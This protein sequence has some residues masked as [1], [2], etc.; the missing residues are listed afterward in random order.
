[1]H[2]LLLTIASFRIGETIKVKILRDGQEKI[3]PVTIAER[4]ERAELASAQQMGEAFGMTVQEIT[5]QIVQHLGLAIKKGLIVVDVTEGSI[6]EEVGLQPQ[7]IILEVNK[8]RVTAMKDYQ[9][10]MTKAGKKGSITLLIRRGKASF[11]VP[12]M[13]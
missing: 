9:R 10:E 13:K 1:M 3:I 6:A 2:E 4:T 7:D 12:L 11:Y 5:P 8:V